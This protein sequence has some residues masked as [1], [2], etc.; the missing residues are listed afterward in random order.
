MS[1]KF[2]I[3]NSTN[4]DKT[5]EMDRINRIAK[6]N[7]IWESYFFDMVMRYTK[8]YG[9]LYKLPQDK[10]AKVGFA[11]IKYICSCRDVL[12]E[13]EKLGVDEPKTL[14]QNQYR[15]QMIDNIFGVLGC[16]TLRNFVTTFPIDKTY[17]GAKW[18]CKDYF[19]TMEVLSKMDWDKPIGRDELSEL[20][21]DYDNADL[22]HA[23]VE[24]TTAM[25]AIY[26]AQTGKG[27][28]ETWCDNI[29]IPTY[30]EDRETGIRKNNQTGDIM[31]S[32]K[33]SHLQIVK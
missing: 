6:L 17:D 29:G 23:Y 2:T 31:K 28:A 10:L 7:E 15:F 16:M 25:S 32:K 20:L 33:V 26:R 22:R 13:N 14:K 21:W 18:E 27:I 5:K 3:I 9:T 30:T 1:N 4:E 11:G 24:F 19:S 12:R 8:E